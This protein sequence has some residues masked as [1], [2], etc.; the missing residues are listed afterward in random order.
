MGENEATSG[1]EGR[2]GRGRGDESEGV[3][4]ERM[5][6]RAGWRSEMEEDLSANHR[7]LTS[8]NGRAS[9]GERTRQR[10]WQTGRA[11][12][13]ED[14]ERPCIRGRLVARKTPDV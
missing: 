2:D 1:M 14:D 13:M 5:R 7:P 6:R 10:T 3:E 8:R 9:S 12:G 11:S 4:W